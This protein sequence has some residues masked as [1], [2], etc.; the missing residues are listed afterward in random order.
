M[1]ATLETLLS[2]CF[3]TSAI[4]HLDEE[5]NQLLVDLFDADP[6]DLSLLLAAWHRIDLIFATLWISDADRALVIL[7]PEEIYLHRLTSDAGM[8]SRVTEVLGAYQP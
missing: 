8:Q 3:T 5:G 2:T 4:Q 7:T 6:Q 1:L